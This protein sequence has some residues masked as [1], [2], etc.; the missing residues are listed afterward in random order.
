MGTYMAE[1]SANLFVAI[2]YWTGQG[3]ITPMPARDR[4]WDPNMTEP[5]DGLE[6]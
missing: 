3:I 5:D 1:F 4:Y 2:D 6:I